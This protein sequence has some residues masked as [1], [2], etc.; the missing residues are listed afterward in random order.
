MFQAFQSAIQ[1]FFI[2]PP[3]RNN[4]TQLFKYWKCE[5]VKQIPNALLEIHRTIIAIFSSIENGV[6]E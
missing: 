2:I 4:S 6:K 1:N 5:K 3:K